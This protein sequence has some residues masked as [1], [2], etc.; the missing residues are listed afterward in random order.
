MAKTKKNKK[1]VRCTRKNLG[2]SKLVTTINNTFQDIIQSKNHPKYHRFFDHTASWK[3]IYDDMIHKNNIVKHIPKEYKQVSLDISNIKPVELCKFTPSKKLTNKQLKDYYTTMLDPTISDFNI[4]KKMLQQMNDYNMPSTISDL[5]N[6]KRYN[7]SNAINVLILGAGP[8]G[9]FTALELHNLYNDFSINWRISTRRVNILVIDN[10]IYKE[11]IKL[12]YTRNTKFSYCL[13]LLQPH[14]KNIFCWKYANRYE[15]KQFDYISVLE[16][17]LYVT[18]YNKNIPMFF[19][20]YF[21]N[22]AIL[23]K[24]IE[25]E[26]V[27]VVYDCTGGRFKTNLVHPL[28][29]CGYSFKKGKEEVKINKENQYYELYINN[30]LYRRPLYAIH[31]Y[32]DTLK[33][34]F[35]EN[36]YVASGDEADTMILTLYNNKCLLL[37]DYIRISSHFKSHNLK[38]WL[39]WAIEITNS[40]RKQNN[41]SP[42]DNDEI[43]YVR[44][45]SYELGRRHSPFAATQ[46][47]NA[48]YIRV[49]DSLG[50]SEFGGTLGL[51]HSMLFSKYICTLLGTF[52]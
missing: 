50:T 26:K 36:Q 6:W 52:L 9:L 3:T 17:L 10:R 15:D 30:Q 18:A 46:L 27:H 41:E 45:S 42:I 13:T 12:P 40:E 44:I 23:K 29:W 47:N 5:S 33:E 43:K 8:I 22:D 39:P 34:I 28:P 48:A 31:M 35:T 20:T 37:N 2:V 25:K 51:D 38:Y 16:N 24:F 11:G 32:N 7:D 14:L 21:E 4:I 49:G 19:T 1:S